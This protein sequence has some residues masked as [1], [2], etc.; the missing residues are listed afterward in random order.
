MDQ[1]ERVKRLQEKHQQA[2][3]ALERAKVKLESAQGAYDSLVIQIEQEF[4]IQV[5]DIEGH[6]QSLKSELDE[7]L[8][9]VEQ[10]LDKIEL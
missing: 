2:Q 7:L 5:D 10:K 4:N 1:V 6:I 8:L 3:I 9:S